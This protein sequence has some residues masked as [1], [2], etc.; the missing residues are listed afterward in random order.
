M[1]IDKNHGKI[2][3]FDA[4]QLGFGEGDESTVIASNGQVTTYFRYGWTV[5][6][7]AVFTNLLLRVLRDDGAQVYLNGTEVFRKAIQAAP[8]RR[9]IIRSGACQSTQ[10]RR[11]FR[12]CRRDAA[13]VR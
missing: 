9:V 7:P 13:F 8:R 5:A 3:S 2:D 6:D 12:F 10:A 11:A 1:L 4:G